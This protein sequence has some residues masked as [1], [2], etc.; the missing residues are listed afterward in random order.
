MSFRFSRLPNS[1]TNSISTFHDLYF[2][3]NSPIYHSKYDVLGELNGT[4]TELEKN[5][6]I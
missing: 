3:P 2:G 4:S 5:Y 1:L 6:H